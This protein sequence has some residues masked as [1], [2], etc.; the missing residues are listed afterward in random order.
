MWEATLT[1]SNVCYSS[2]LDVSITV[3]DEPY[4]IQLPSI[5][6]VVLGSNI[7]LPLTLH[8]SGTD[9]LEYVNWWFGTNVGG[10][11]FVRTMDTVLTIPNF[12]SEWAGNWFVEVK[13][14]CGQIYSDTFSLTAVSGLPVLSQLGSAPHLWISY[15]NQMKPTAHILNV[16]NQQFV[17][18]LFDVNG[19]IIWQNSFSNGS[20]EDFQ[21]P[22]RSDDSAMGV[23]FLQV[24]LDNKNLVAV[25]KL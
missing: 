23:Y 18:R 25:V 22:V 4:I 11:S 24:L 21:F 7:I 6:A 16:E 14:A 1:A 13:P 8:L 12:T 9:T 3:Q 10:F 20:N 17:A 19:R 5:Q 15:N 2:Y